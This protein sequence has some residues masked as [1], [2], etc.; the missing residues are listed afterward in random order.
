M[1]KRLI[2][3]VAMVLSAYAMALSANA[4]GVPIT[5]AHAKSDYELS[6]KV[7]T[8]LKNKMVKA[9]N[10]VGLV[11]N[12]PLARFALLPTIGIVSENTRA[13]V[14]VKTDM[15]LDFTFSIVDWMTGNVY[16]TESI[17]VKST[18]T[19]KQNTIAKA[20]SSLKLDTPEFQS[21]L[22]RAQ[23]R[24]ISYYE[25][26]LKNLLNQAKNL[27]KQG[28]YEHALYVLGEIPSAVNGYDRVVAA[29]NECYKLYND[30]LAADLCQK[31]EAAWIA[32]PNQN[33]AQEALA[34]LSQIPSNTSSASR[35]KAIM[36]KIEKKL[37]ADEKREWALREKEL[38]RRHKETMAATQAARAIGVAYA[39][40]Q[41]KTVTKI[42]L[43]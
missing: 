26:N 25:A 32:S 20:A 28:E 19:T 12:D 11:N 31:A 14:P 35:A 3:I 22:G 17:V 27:S 10:A 43:W 30:K 33:G 24:I 21:F 36:N 5:P 41:P 1:N 38:N 42:I 9:L 29:M 39:K 37:S 2:Y 7:D 23:Q 4:Q 6:N 16:D 15:E 18:G 13:S 8:Q 40:N 34:L